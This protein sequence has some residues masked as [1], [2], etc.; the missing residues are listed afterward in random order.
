[1]HQGIST[2]SDVNN[3]PTETF[4]SINQGAVR[5][6]PTPRYFWK[7]IRDVQT[8]TATAF[9]GKNEEIISKICT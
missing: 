2:L 7:V 8:N 1:M 9:V 6:M 4:L 5:G 3:R